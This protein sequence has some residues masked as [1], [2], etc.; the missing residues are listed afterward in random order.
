MSA[1]F[2]EYILSHSEQSPALP[3]LY[4]E[5]PCFDDLFF[6]YK[7]TLPAPEHVQ[8]STFL[9]VW[10][11]TLRNKVYD[12]LKDMDF[13]VKLRRRRAVGFT[14]CT[15][16]EHLKLQVRLAKTKA[17]RELAVG[18][19]VDHFRSVRRDRDEIARIM[20]L[21]RICEK[22]VGFAIDAADVGKWQTPL[23]KSRAKVH[24]DNNVHVPHFLFL[25][26]TFI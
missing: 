13:D 20:L 9:K 7:E 11:Q 8:K 21:C 24:T 5:P 15:L 10:Y 17:D 19:K 16:C 25:M 4:V 26:F 2:K 23:T 1:F 14:A 12:P 18:K 3:L 22:F 6:K